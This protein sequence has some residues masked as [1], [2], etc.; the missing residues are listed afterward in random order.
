MWLHM[1]SLTSTMGK[2]NVV[3]LL[4]IWYNSLTIR[5]DVERVG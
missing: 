4:Y 1:T 5:L 3:Q 2:T